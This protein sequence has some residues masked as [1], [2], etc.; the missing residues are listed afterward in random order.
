MPEEGRWVAKMRVGIDTGGTFTDLVSLEEGRLCLGKVPSTPEAPAE[1]VRA[2]LGPRV[3]HPR[4]EFCH[5][6]TVATNALLER[7]G[8]RTALVTNRGFEDLIEIG[9]QA[10]LNIYALHPCRPRPLADR[11]SR[12]G[13]GA[14][15]GPGGEVW[16]TFEEGELSQLPGK[17]G[18]IGAEAVAVCLLHSYR[19]G[20]DER[21]VRA[22][23]KSL[24]IPV[25]ISYE[26]LPRFREYERASTTLVN[27][28][29]LPLMERYLAEIGRFS[30][31]PV[32]VMQSTGGVLEA[33]RVAPFPCRLLLSGPAAG[34]LGAKW[35]A[36]RHGVERLLTL[37]MG[38]TST[39]V[40][41]VDGSIRL[42]DRNEIGGLAV[43]LPM[44][45]LHTI[46]S[47]GGSI[48]RID[49]GG[50]LKVGPESAGANPGP[51]CY[52]RSMVPTVTDAN[53]VLGRLPEG[54]ELGGSLHLSRERSLR[55]IHSL[56][57]KNSLSVQRMAEG[58]VR[59][60]NANM[61]Q[62][63]RVV[64]VRRGVDPRPLTLVAFGGAGPLHAAAIASGL[65]IRRILV[66][67]LAGTLSA[68]GMVV[69]ERVTQV[70]MS[71]LKPANE[72]SLDEAARWFDQQC[73]QAGEN[74]ETS[75]IP[76][77]DARYQ[78]QSFELTVPF[79]TD[80]RQ[81]I[82]AFREAH[83]QRFG[84]VHDLPVELVHLS[85]RF[86]GQQP[87]KNLPKVSPPGK[88]RGVR[89]ARAY[90]RGAWQEVPQIGQGQISQETSF[91]G[92]AIVTSSHA[93]CWIPQGWNL[94]GTSTGD[95]W[96][97]K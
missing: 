34:L 54:I 80:L 59:V 94:R 22:A 9:R 26:V 16:S 30:K 49:A 93:T 85:V 5:G 97:E 91:P 67:A 52:G 53:L 40:A 81:V 43:A 87:L 89:V 86:V 76:E 45:D 17:I 65:G 82:S 4:L 15:R 56:A 3:D 25:S 8:A 42:G 57:R 95:F 68:L 50:L 83:R 90:F 12:F 32:L 19:G 14:R 61:E 44:V 64:S 29:L 38:G 74:L 75:I 20:E 69:A 18:A 33:Q 51:A 46:G 84:T 21:N 36:R 77:I 37:D 58:I 24:G 6:T 63:L 78:G 23:L 88:Q 79:C 71:L 7:K 47:G 55:A 72:R 10:R 13:V 35:I 28:Y 92:P 96:I 39:D 31:R 27:A 73:R 11:G 60:A 2:A 1:A 66:P 41:L 48:A 70:T 62:A